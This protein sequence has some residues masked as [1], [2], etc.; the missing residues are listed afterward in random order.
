[1]SFIVLLSVTLMKREVTSNETNLY[2]SLT[3]CDTD[4]IL[5]AASISEYS[6][7]ASGFVN[8]VISIE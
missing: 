1:M 2:P 7:A 6:F 3:S 5:S 8:F 4:Y